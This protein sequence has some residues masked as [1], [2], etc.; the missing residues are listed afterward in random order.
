[1]HTLVENRNLRK[2]WQVYRFWKCNG[3]KQ[4]TQAL[5]GLLHELIYYINISTRLQQKLKLK[6]LWLHR[7]WLHDHYNNN[8]NRLH[9]EPGNPLP[10]FTLL[11]L[12]TNTPLP[13]RRLLPTGS[14][15]G[16][17]I[18]LTPSDDDRW[19][20]TAGERVWFWEN[21]ASFICLKCCPLILDFRLE[22]IVFKR[23][24]QL[25]AEGVV[26]DKPVQTPLGWHFT[27]LP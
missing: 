21:W 23:K 14:A 7:L 19:T 2:N 8:N 9:T 5:S 22:E 3:A 12:V 1:M 11:T 6:I 4:I 10:T 27:H 16:R 24:I 26:P 17:D 18:N 13:V 20:V 25:K 15:D